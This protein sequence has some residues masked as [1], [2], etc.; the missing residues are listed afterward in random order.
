[1]SIDRDALIEK[2]MP[3]A[4]RYASDYFTE[5]SRFD[6]E[7]RKSVAF[8]A[9][10]KA[11]DGYDPTTG[12]SFGTYA[13]KVIWRMLRREAYKQG[14]Q[15]T[16]PSPDS[17]SKP[18]EPKQQALGTYAEASLADDPTD[19][20]DQKEYVAWIM[21]RLTPDEQAV[22][23]GIMEGRKYSEIHLKSRNSRSASGRSRAAY[24]KK[25]LSQKIRAM[26]M[27]ALLEFVRRKLR[28][29]DLLC[30]NDEQTD[31]D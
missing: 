12:Y 28:H 17:K 26:E 15:M 4:I 10:I 7:E 24:V 18:K 2:W 3:L 16:R 9:L 20:L 19:E 29:A 23:L 11:A 13:G 22:A 27:E 21:E 31:Q 1:M 8:M 14:S 5:D 6:F 25:R 30:E